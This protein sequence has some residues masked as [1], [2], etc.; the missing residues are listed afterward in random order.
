MIRALSPPVRCL[1]RFTSADGIS[2]GLRWQLIGVPWHIAGLRTAVS[3]SDFEVWLID[4]SHANGQPFGE[5]IH[6]FDGVDL[7]GEAVATATPADVLDLSA[8]VLQ[9]YAMASYTS[10]H[11]AEEPPERDPK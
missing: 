3:I 7:F 1:A 6:I 4:Q 10:G 8:A 2:C 9:F 11:L 5:T